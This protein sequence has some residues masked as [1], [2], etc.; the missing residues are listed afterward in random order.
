MEL[1]R[2]PSSKELKLI[3][4]LVKKA[5][6]KIQLSII[7]DLLVQPM[8]DG[9]MGSLYII[10]KGVEP[11]NRIFGKQISENQFVD[12]DGVEVIVS[13]NIDKE[14]FLYELDVWKTDFSPLI[15]IPE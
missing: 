5:S 6:D 13:L 12:E 15:K 11:D 2:K 4:E 7:E 9:G 3:E 14:G 1:I 8:E 10:P